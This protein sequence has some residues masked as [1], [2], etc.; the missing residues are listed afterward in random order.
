MDKIEE[1]I[2]K[3]IDDN[4]DKIIEFAR[5]VYSHP[6]LGYK[7]KRTSQKVYEILKEIVRK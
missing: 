5:E 1:K 4:R 3:L 6:E 7:E 2:I